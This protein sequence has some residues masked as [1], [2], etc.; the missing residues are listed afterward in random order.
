MNTVRQIKCP[1]KSNEFVAEV[2]DRD[3]IYDEVVHNC[4]LDMSRSKRCRK[5][6]IGI[7]LVVIEM[8]TVHCKLA[9]WW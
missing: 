3:S 4:T 6:V 7:P 9:I 5:T 2:W 1:L 8:I